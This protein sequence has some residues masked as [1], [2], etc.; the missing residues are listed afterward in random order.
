MNQTPF[1]AVLWTTIIPQIRISTGTLGA[2]PLKFRVSNS[3]LS[4]RVLPDHYRKD[5]TFWQQY[6]C[7]KQYYNRTVSGENVEVTQTFTYLAQRY[8]IHPTSA[9]PWLP[10]TCLF[11]QWPGSH[12]GWAESRPLQFAS[13]NYASMGM[14]RDALR[15]IP[16][17]NFCPV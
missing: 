4:I 8:V 1:S 10:V 3:V 6:L 11:V 2:R 9:N 12:E 17:I 14:W 15:R 13:T 5:C 16:P 7:L